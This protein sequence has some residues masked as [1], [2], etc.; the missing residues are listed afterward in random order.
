MKSIVEKYLTHYSE[1]RKKYGKKTVVLMEVGQFYEIISLDK[2][3]SDFVEIST[4]L[5]LYIGMQQNNGLVYYFIGFPRICSNK[6][7]KK[8]IDDEK[9]I[10]VTIDKD[11]KVGVCGYYGIPFDDNDNNN[12]YIDEIKGDHEEII[13]IVI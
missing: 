2:N 9:Y 13:T 11:N 3:D 12:E 1:Y 6:Y 8:L 5:N 4:L 10:V 7:Y